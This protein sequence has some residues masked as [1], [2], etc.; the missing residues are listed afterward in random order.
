MHH[1]IKDVQNAFLNGL[2]LHTTNLISNGNA[3][4]SYGW[5][6]IARWVNG[7]IITRKGGMYSVTTAKHIGPIRK[8]PKT[9]EAS[10]ITEPFEA[11]M[12][13]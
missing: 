10:E 4:F 9:I 7:Q 12:K 13:I 1:T 6:E 5:Y 11:E 2:S 8:H 3:L